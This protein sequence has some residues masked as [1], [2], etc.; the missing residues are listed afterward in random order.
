[1]KK[2]FN[3][4][5]LILALSLAL[6]FSVA[7]FAADG[8]DE[9]PSPDIV[10]YNVTYGET[11][12]LRAAVA[13]ESVPSGATVSVK[14][15]GEYPTDS[16]EVLDEFTLTRTQLKQFDNAYFYV[17]TSNRAVSA[18]ALGTKFFMQAEYEAEG[19]TV[20]GA[21]AEYSVAEYLYEKLYFEDYV[22]KTAEDGDDYVRKT[23]YEGILAFGAGAQHLVLDVAPEYYMDELSYC[24]VEDGTVNG[25]KAALTAPETTLTVAYTGSEDV[26]LL[27]SWIYTS[28]EGGETE[29][30]PVNDDKT[31]TLAAPAEAFKLTPVFKNPYLIT[32]EN[33]SIAK[34]DVLN[35]AGTV[36]YSNVP[37][38]GLTAGVVANPQDATDN[39][40]QIVGTP[41]SNQ[42]FR[43]GFASG[44][45]TTGDTYT[46]EA[47]M[48]ISS[49]DGS[50]NKVTGNE[51]F[52]YI[53]FRTGNVYAV[54]LYYNKNADGVNVKSNASDKGYDNIANLPVDQWFNFKMIAV[55]YTVDGVKTLDSYFYVN[56]NLVG[57]QTEVKNFGGSALSTL[58][59]TALNIKLNKDIY[60]NM[61][62]DDVIFF[63]TQSEG[64]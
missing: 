2:V 3:L 42:H 49:V 4:K 58:D 39:V 54:N 35:D 46:F 18:S 59:A 40:F 14:V 45:N 29:E 51:N 62:L 30:L 53:D 22:S 37:A 47:D 10:I 21:V 57:S 36:I 48:Y 63:R 27:A 20:L 15:Y 5:T 50:G 25:K 43:L 38:N 19:E 16:S 7:A 11:F 1:M 6:I 41:A 24:V 12:N 33:G 44:T 8:A 60:T 26:S 64:N 55:T 32:F 56:G 9:N 13:D 31:L 61:Y 17:G 28:L 52:G 34:N 23:F